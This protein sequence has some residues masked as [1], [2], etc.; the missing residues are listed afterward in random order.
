MDRK[1]RK[2]DYFDTGE[3]VKIGGC[4]YRRN[5]AWIQAKKG[6]RPVELRRALHGSAIFKNGNDVKNRENGK[7]PWQS[8]RKCRFA[9]W[10]FP[11][12]VSAAGSQ[13][14][15]ILAA[16]R[17]S[18]RAEIVRETSG[19]RP[20]NV[21]KKTAC[22]SGFCGYSVFALR[23]RRPLRTDIRERFGNL[24]QVVRWLNC[25]SSGNLSN[26]GTKKTLS[27]R[28]A[29]FFDFGGFMR[30]RFRRYP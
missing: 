4:E 1:R 16:D 25:R 17:I 15:R 9:S 12:I 26:T 2:L 19:K 5:R 7:I 27:W 24:C 22:N 30:Y 21:R 18:K 8:W 6:V 29:F 23:T 20:G 28:F 13:S 14:L 10:Q 3:I 11:G